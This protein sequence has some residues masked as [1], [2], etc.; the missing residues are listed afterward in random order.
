MAITVHG[1][2][3]FVSGS[4]RLHLYELCDLSDPIV[5]DLG[6]WQGT[7]AN[8]LRLWVDRFRLWIW[9]ERWLSIVEITRRTPNLLTPQ[10]L[11]VPQGC[12]ILAFGHGWVWLERD[13]HRLEASIPESV[14][15]GEWQ[16][17]IEFDL[18]ASLKRFTVD[19]FQEIAFVIGGDKILFMDKLGGVWSWAR[20]MKQ[21][22]LLSEG[23]KAMLLPVWM[24]WRGKSEFVLPVQQDGQ[25]AL[26]CYNPQTN[27]WRTLPLQQSPSGSNAVA[28]GETLWLPHN[29]GQQWVGYDADGISVASEILPPNSQTVYGFSAGKCLWVL[30]RDGNTLRFFKLMPKLQETA[31][32]DIKDQPFVLGHAYGDKGVWIAIL[33]G[34]G[35]V[36]ITEF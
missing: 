22:E 18:P 26:R 17:K 29:G 15:K 27:T 13:E 3:V 30:Q 5:M 21:L 19:R 6:I 8:E 7:D 31:V 32:W 36:C 16:T 10:P 23:E 25:G 9:S 4:E 28:V 2:L 34:R 35:E 20:G 11:P 33:R 1:S 14:I 12:R 24:V